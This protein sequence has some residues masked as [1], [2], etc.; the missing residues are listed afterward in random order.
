PPMRRKFASSLR[1]RCP[2][3]MAEMDR[4]IVEI[5]NELKLLE[6]KIGEVKRRLPAHSVKPPIM[7]ELL[8]LE[9][10]RDELLKI[11]GRLK[12]AER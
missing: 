3:G 2:R 7:M 12:P 4:T 8:Q 1:C 11:I 6:E 9:D 10:R 5:E